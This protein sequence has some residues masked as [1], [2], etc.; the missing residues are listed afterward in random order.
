MGDRPGPGY[1]VDRIDVNGDYEP[2]NCRWASA[3]QQGRNQRRTIM[4]EFRGSVIPLMEA[5]EIANVGYEMV[6]RRLRKGC[7]ASRLFDPSRSLSWVKPISRR[8]K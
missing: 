1:S 2:G 7:D 8:T 4:V 3:K 6:R 5:C